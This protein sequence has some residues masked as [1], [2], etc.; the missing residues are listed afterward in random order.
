MSFCF[1]AEPHTPHFNV[2]QNSCATRFQRKTPIYVRRLLC[3]QAT[4]N[5]GC[6][7]G[8]CSLWRYSWVGV[9][10]EEP[11]EGFFCE[12]TCCLSTSILP[13]KPWV[14]FF[15]KEGSALP[16]G[17]GH[18]SE[19]RGLGWTR[20]P[21]LLLNPMVCDTD[22]PGLFATGAHGADEHP[23]TPSSYRI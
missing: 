22:D 14:L 5:W 19:I 15:S 3:H 23:V 2:V 4:L 21:Q 1:C 9:F 6:G 7:G 18:P 20:Q 13:C 8:D 10:R 17:E 11:G 16:E 12:P